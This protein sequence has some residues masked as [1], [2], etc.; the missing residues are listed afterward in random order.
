MEFEID[1]TLWCI[2]ENNTATIPCPIWQACIILT[3]IIMEIKQRWNA[4]TAMAPE[5]GERVKFDRNSIWKSNRLIFF[6]LSRSSITVKFVLC[7]R[8]N[9]HVFSRTVI[10]PVH[11]NDEKEGWEIL[12]D[13]TCLVAQGHCIAPWIRVQ[14]DFDLPL[15]ETTVGAIRF[16]V[17]Y[18]W[19]TVS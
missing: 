19:H 4:R 15:F 8:W 12:L 6:F 5:V 14:P 9:A 7:S 11:N 1:R 17:I 10:R 3:A 2:L 18:G 16:T 13:N